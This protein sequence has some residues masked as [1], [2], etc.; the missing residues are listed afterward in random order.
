LRE[1]EERYRALTEAA[2]EAIGIHD[3]EVWLEVNAELAASFG[4][5]PEQ[6]IGASVHETVAPEEWPRVHEL[7]RQ[8][9]GREFEF[10]TQRSEGRTTH[11]EVCAKIVPYHGRQAVLVAGRDISERK[12]AEAER[13]RVAAERQ[14][15][16]STVIAAQEQERLTLSRELHDHVGQMLAVLKM[17]AAWLAQQAERPDEVRAVAARL[18]AKVD[19]MLQVVRDLSYKLRPP[20]LD[21]LGLACAVETLVGEIST[22]SS[23]TFDVTMSGPERLPTEVAT[24]LYRIAQESLSNVIRHSQARHCD[25]EIRAERDGIGLR[26]EHD[27]VVVEPS[28][29]DSDTALGIGG[30]RERALLLGGQFEIRPRDGGGTV[31]QVQVPLRELTAQAESSSASGD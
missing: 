2:F 17:D 3:G 26:V 21:D 11:Y 7:S 22:H 18:D 9:R 19:E 29:L 4:S 15:L 16:A 27:G 14:R 1:S 12:R 31:L 5:S 24:A 13:E 28:T 10:S 23:I 30:M 6:L 25:V 20:V 8:K